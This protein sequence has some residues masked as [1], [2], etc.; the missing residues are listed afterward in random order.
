M[1]GGAADDPVRFEVDVIDQ[2][3]LYLRADSQEEKQMWYVWRG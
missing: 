2:Q 3:T 1:F